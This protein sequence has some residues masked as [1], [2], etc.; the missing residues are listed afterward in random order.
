MHPCLTIVEVQH[1]IFRQVRLGNHPTRANPTLARLA[2]TCR[3]FNDTA[4]NILWEE[5]PSITYLIRCLP[6]NLWRIESISA[7]KQLMTFQRTMLLSDW[8]IFRRYSS[9]VRSLT[10]FES[11][12]LNCETLDNNVILSLSHPPHNGPLIPYLK[13]LCW[14]VS[15]EDHVP[16]LPVLFTHTL[17]DVTLPSFSLRSPEIQT[18]L[19][20]TCP[21]L[22]RLYVKRLYVKVASE[23]ERDNADEQRALSESIMCLHFLESL[24]CQFCTLDEAAVL[25]LSCLP[26]LIELSLDL[27]DESYLETVKRSLVPPA[28]ATLQS[29][30]LQVDALSPLISFL[31]LMH[32][33]LRQAWFTVKAIPTQ[34]V[35]HSFFNTLVNACDPVQLSEIMLSVGS[36][37]WLSSAQREQVSLVTFQPLLALPNMERFRFDGMFN[38]LLDDEAVKTVSDCWPNLTSFSLNDRTVDFAEIDQ[39]YSEIP[40]SCGVT[41]DSSCRI[42]NFITSPINHPHTI[43]DFLQDICP[44]LCSVSATWCEYMD[45]NDMEQCWDAWEGVNNLLC[46]LGTEQATQDGTGEQ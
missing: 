45:E 7:H 15:D 32:F 24:N 46:F 41:I 25:H 18:R 27:Q 43:A 12:M 28:F 1:A 8:E 17:V 40:T 42:A 2:C 23:R 14:T 33:K 36:R 30:S 29:L 4:L 5:L 11:N 22:K 13:I 21:S 37:R 6:R 35:L 10:A 38:I 9:R 34:D 20:S 39:P 16:L 31:Q 44:R 19:T 26:S 3:T